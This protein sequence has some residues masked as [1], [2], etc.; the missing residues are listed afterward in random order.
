[1][2]TGKSSPF[3][4]V[5]GVMAGCDRYLT[6]PVDAEQLQTVLKKYIPNMQPH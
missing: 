4:K 1:M 6:K 5:R 2:L 3:N